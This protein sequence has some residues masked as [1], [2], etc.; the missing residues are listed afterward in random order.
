MTADHWHYASDI[1]GGAAEHHRHYDTE[2]EIE[3]LRRELAAAA[4]SIREMAG[5][6]RQLRSQAG[7][8]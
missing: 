5:D 7:R 8:P 1:H 4:E 3:A 2:R 6:L